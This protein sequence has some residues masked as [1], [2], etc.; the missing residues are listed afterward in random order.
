ML[1]DWWTPAPHADQLAWSRTVAVG[2]NN[3]D[4]T[5]RCPRGNVRARR[6]SG[7]DV[8]INRVTTERR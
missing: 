4:I 6:T 2:Y 8:V 1:V 7:E 3:I 5:R